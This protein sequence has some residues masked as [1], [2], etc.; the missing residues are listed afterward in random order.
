MFLKIVACL[1]LGLLLL[2]LLIR[3]LAYNPQKRQ[4][5][6]SAKPSLNLNFK[7]I[8]CLATG[9]YSTFFFVLLEKGVVSNIQNNN[10]LFH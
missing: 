3:N 10:A 8:V 1:F 9:T 7:R 4:P 2:L 5:E 6:D